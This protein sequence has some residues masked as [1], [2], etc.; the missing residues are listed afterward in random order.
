MHAPYK[1]HFL[2]SIEREIPKENKFTEKFVFTKPTELHVKCKKKTSSLANSAK[3][4]DVNLHDSEFV[5]L[6]V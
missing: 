2:Y 3:P 4:I 6:W 1:S 5:W